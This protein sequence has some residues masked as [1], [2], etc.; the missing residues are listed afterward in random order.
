MVK[1]E[2]KKQIDFHLEWGWKN[3]PLWIFFLDVEENDRINTGFEWVFV[4]QGLGIKFEWVKEYTHVN[5]RAIRSFKR[6]HISKD[7]V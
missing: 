5:V 6:N 7:T 1:K 2:N 3:I 4:I